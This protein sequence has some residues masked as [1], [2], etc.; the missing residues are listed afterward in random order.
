MSQK[1]KVKHRAGSR[2]SQDAHFMEGTRVVTGQTWQD[3]RGALQDSAVLTGRT[4]A[5]CLPDN[6]AMV[7]EA[8]L[9]RTITDNG[10][11]SR[12]L[13]RTACVA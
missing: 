7:T 2:Q 3:R 13:A 4:S 1:E 12:A 10:T 5:S 11:V 8:E 9:G 6:T